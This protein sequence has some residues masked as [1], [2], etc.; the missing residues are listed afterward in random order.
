[1]QP[2]AVAD[3]G[4]VRARAGR[5]S[6]RGRVCVARASET[7]SSASAARSTSARS[8]GRPSSSEASSSRS[9]TSRPIRPAAASMRPAE[10]S[11]WSGCAVTGAAHQL[12]VA[13]DRGQRR[14]QLVARRRTRT[15]A[16]G[17]RCPG[18]P[19]ATASTWSSIALTALP[20]WPD[21]GRG[22]A[23]GHPVG[24]RR[25][26]RGPAAA[27]RPARRSRRPAAAGAASAG[28][29]T[30]RRRATSSRRQ[31]REQLDDRNVR[32]TD[33]DPRQ[34][35]RRDDGRLPV[36]R[37]PSGDGAR[38]AGLLSVERHRCGRR[39]P[40][41]RAHGRGARRA[42]A[43]TGSGD[44]ELA[45]PLPT[46][47]SG[48]RAA[49]AARRRYTVG[50]LLSPGADRADTAPWPGRPGSTTC[51]GPRSGRRRPGPPASAAARR[52]SPRR[53]P[54]S[55]TTTTSEQAH[56][57]PPPQRHRLPAFGEGS[58]RVARSVPGAPATAAPEAGVRGRTG[59]RRGPTE[60]LGRTERAPR[61]GAGDA[62]SGIARPRRAQH[63]ADTAHG[64]D[65]RLVVGVDLASQVADVLLDDVAAAGEVVV[66]H[67]VEDLRLATRRC[68]R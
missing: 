5:A 2:R 64:V 38:L 10:A 63:V 33:V 35:L 32:G 23:V 59:E 8:S 22:G 41:H 1:M 26:R 34:R 17:P 39:V 27:S 25:R 62:G 54:T 57:E 7:A 20:T 49:V 21:L 47:R 42:C 29:T 68:A 52:T 9:S 45:G 46:S 60:A 15:G 3:D 67:A 24:D 31:Q 51:R 13:A 44:A 14:P 48:L 61:G 28:S 4:D 56:D 65:Q 18:G 58:A 43:D 37:R 16:A 12:G 50:A 6:R 53:Q 40:R 11:A 36:R 66:P 19:A 30:T 55:A